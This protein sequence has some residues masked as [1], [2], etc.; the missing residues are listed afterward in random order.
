MVNSIDIGT[1]ISLG[2]IA[3]VVSQSFNS[4]QV[5]KL[6]TEMKTNWAKTSNHDHDIACRGGDCRPKTTQVNFHE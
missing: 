6:R 1:A 2:S 5:S 4:Y 3:I